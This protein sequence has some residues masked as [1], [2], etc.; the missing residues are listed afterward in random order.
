MQSKGAAMRI[1]GRS[2]R[3]AIRRNLALMALVALVVACAPVMRKHG[4][5]PIEED[6]AQVVVGVD[7][8]ETV[9]EKIGAP[10]ITGV[11]NESGIYYVSSVFRHFGA[12]APEEISREVVAISF[13]AQGLV[14]NVARYGLEDGEVVVLSRRVTEDNVRDSTLIRQLLGAIGNFSATDLIGSN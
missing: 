4:Y 10:T 12:A 8:R 14:T 1:M 6:L 3:T 9:L 2:T 11:L 7:T 13:N 5:A